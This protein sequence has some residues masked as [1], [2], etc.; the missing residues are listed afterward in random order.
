ML[1]K[2]IEKTSSELQQRR[3]EYC[4]EN[5]FEEGAHAKMHESA[6]G[7]RGGWRSL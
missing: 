7:R 5:E 6:D 1:E 4:R 3:A 2:K